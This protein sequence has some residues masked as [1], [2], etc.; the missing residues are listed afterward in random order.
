[1]PPRSW[2]SFVGASPASALVDEPLFESASALHLW[3][4]I[5]ALASGDER[6]V[7]LV[8]AFEKAGDGIGRDRT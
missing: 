6:S 1:V 8:D 7:T 3:S 4:S 2:E 5:D